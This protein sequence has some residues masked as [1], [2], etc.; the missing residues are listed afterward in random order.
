[1]SNA[2]R[3]RDVLNADVPRFG[4]L[5]DAAAALELMA[6]TQ[7]YNLPI[8]SGKQVKDTIDGV[9]Y[10][11]LVDGKKS[12]LLS[13]FARDDLDPHGIDAD[14]FLDAMP[15][16]AN[17]LSAAALSAA[18]TITTSTAFIEGLGEVQEIDVFRARSLG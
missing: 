1:M 10:T 4:A 18:R 9:E 14:I 15:S 6:E 8:M 16:G 3:I 7:S 12:L 17:P 5:D 13:L 2:V 11:A